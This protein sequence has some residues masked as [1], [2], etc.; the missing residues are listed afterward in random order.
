MREER[1]ADGKVVGREV[2]SHII[3][4]NKY[5]SSMSVEDEK[6]RRSTMTASHD[7]RH[8]ECKQVREKSQ[9]EKRD[10]LLQSIGKWEVFRRDRRRIVG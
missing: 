9:E 7:L 3:E 5:L 4:R 2:V 8:R 6:L 10:A 1:G